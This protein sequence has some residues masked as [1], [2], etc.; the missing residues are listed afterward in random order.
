M[1]E[2]DHTG[3]DRIREIVREEVESIATES[4]REA[5]K[6]LTKAGILEVRGGGE[7]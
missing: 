5:L 4:V 3:E 1:S 2:L 6:A 7:S